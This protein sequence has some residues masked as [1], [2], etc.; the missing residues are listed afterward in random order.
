MIPGATAK[1]RSLLGEVKKLNESADFEISETSSVDDLVNA[2]DGILTHI[3]S[4]FF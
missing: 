3:K 2:V 1:T 4:I